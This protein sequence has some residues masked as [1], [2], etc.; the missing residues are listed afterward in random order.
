LLSNL[1]AREQASKI[2]EPRLGNLDAASYDAQIKAMDPEA[3]GAIADQIRKTAYIGIY[4]RLDP[5]VSDYDIELIKKRAGFS[6]ARSI[7]EMIHDV[8]QIKIDQHLNQVTLRNYA[9]SKAFYVK[10]METIVVDKEYHPALFGQELYEAGDTNARK[11]AIKRVHLFL[12]DF[13]F[14]KRHCYRIVAQ[15][16]VGYPDMGELPF[17]RP[18]VPERPKPG[19]L[20][21]ELLHLNDDIAGVGLSDATLTLRIK[22]FFTRYFDWMDVAERKATIL[23]FYAKHKVY[24][25]RIGFIKDVLAGLAGSS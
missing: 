5:R 2:L 22:H 19:I 20:M 7:E 15:A 6:L 8:R 13:G 1:H 14:P 21:L 16:I 4:S 10:V 18:A 3:R 9:G 23:S 25:K 17:D 24:H 12:Q 11:L